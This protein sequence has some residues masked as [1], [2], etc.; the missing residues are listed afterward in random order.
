MRLFFIFMVMILI[1]I[2]VAAQNADNSPRDPAGLALRYHGY[3]GTPPLP[4][5]TR[6]YVPGDLEQFYV[7]KADT[8]SPV[9][10]EAML[11]AV[12]PSVYL[13]VERGITFNALTLQGNADT[14]SRLFNGLQLH[15]TY[16]EP[17]I[18]PGVGVGNSTSDRVSIP[19][20]DAD[21]HVFVLFIRDGRETNP[22][23]VPVDSLPAEYAPAGITNQHEMV[24][25]N[26]SAL[27]DSPLDDPV[28]ATGI[29]RAL[30]TLIMSEQNPRQAIWLRNALIDNLLRSAFQ[31]GI[32]N[33][34]VS[35]YLTTPSISL[36]AAVPASSLLQEAG[37]SALFLSYAQQRFGLPLTAN[38]YLAPGDGMQPVADILE[39]ESF[40]DPVT[41][42]PI[43]AGD[44][45]AD[46]A[47]TNVINTPIGDGRF[48][49]R[50]ISLGLGQQAQVESISSD[51]FGQPIQETIAPF[52]VRYYAYGSET[53]STVRIEFATPPI[54]ARL[55]MS[56][57]ALL[58]RFYW[59]GETP[60]SHRALTRTVDLRAVREAVLE[61]DEWHALTPGWNYG[62]VT[63]STD[64]G[65]S[66]A[67]LPASG[68]ASDNPNGA[69]YGTGYTGISDWTHRTVDLS[70]YAGQMIQVG[71][72]V[73]S[74]PNY[75]DLGWAIDNLAIEAIDWHD[76]GDSAEGWTLDGWQAIDNT[77][78]SDYWVSAVTTGTESKPPRVIPLIA[79]GSGITEGAWSFALDANESVLLALSLIESDARTEA[80]FGV[81]FS[82]GE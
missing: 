13:W 55:P 31:Q 7:A 18:I 67:I 29:I 49:Y 1:S 28:F 43:S 80:A 32:P 35:A 60:D 33:D 61:F 39:R 59:S 4:L 2:P 72:E 37:A 54:V 9:L 52:G 77:R 10:V 11:A 82:S 24:I 23:Y 22:F 3:A 44:L 79:P 68:T 45:F 81:Q 50:I 20:A 64:G 21:P 70:A 34:Q 73:V 69:A 16:T 65:A 76:P 71:F 38:L 48:T 17:A 26:T 56:G 27:P 6:R 19:D 30:Y 12:S 36:T 53:A 40:V 25:V 51:L 63:V 14:I 5:L 47:L 75:G 46:F 78:P 15:G 58:D 57:R 8:E 42:A 62:Y 66:W 41:G 74:L